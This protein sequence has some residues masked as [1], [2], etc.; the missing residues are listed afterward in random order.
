MTYTELKQY[1]ESKIYENPNEEVSGQDAQDVLL[2]IVDYI[3]HI[4]KKTELLIEGNR[5]VF[6]DI[7]FDNPFS[8]SSYNL[9]FMCYT[10]SGAIVTPTFKR[11]SKT[12]TGFKIWVDQDCYID[13]TATEI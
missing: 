5:A 13:Y 7:E 9:I 10:E 1:I 6:T 2:A 11:S 8:S 12:S 4:Q 3:P